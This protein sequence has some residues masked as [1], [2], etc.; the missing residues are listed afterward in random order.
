MVNMMTQIFN[1]QL[2]K[3]I[4]KITQAI[5]Q[6]KISE[7][8]IK[9]QF[10][11][12]SFDFVIGDSE[13]QQWYDSSPQNQVES[14]NPEFQFIKQLTQPGDIVFECGTH[15][16]LTAMLLSKWVGDEGKI[17]SFEI[18]QHN[19]AIARKN[20]ELN[21]INNVILEEK[22]L[23]SQ[24]SS[25]KIFNKSNSSV[26]PSNVISL[27]WLKNF[28]YGTN[29][30]EI[31]ALDDYVK[32]QSILPTFLKID[33]EGYE[34]EVLKGATEVL[35][36]LPKLEIEIHTEILSRY[37][38]SVEEIFELIDIESYQT[39]VQWSDEEEP[40]PFDLQQKIDRRVHL[41]AIPKQE[42]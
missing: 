13:G 3:N 30:V 38:T 33:V 41:F 20:F 1:L 40:Q 19:A 42:N 6:Q 35:K 11:D 23:G 31:I 24:K 17:V 37:N 29:E 2:E 34:S 18:N 26:T 5:Q 8:T 7:Y 15:H 25:Q 12:I 10:E 9:K 22:G 28:I 32:T 27:G 39:W 14:L 16:G 4:K 21:K 36:T